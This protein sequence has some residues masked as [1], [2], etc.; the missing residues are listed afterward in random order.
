RRETRGVVKA[1]SRL[2]GGSPGIGDQDPA[3]KVFFPR[4]P[5]FHVALFGEPA[6]TASVVGVQVRHDY[7]ADRTFLHCSG[8]RLLPHA[9]RYIGAYAGVDDRPAIAIFEEPQVDVTE[10]ERE[11]HPQPDDTWRNLHR[12]AGFRPV[13]ELVENLLSYA[14]CY[15]ANPW[16]AQLLVCMIA[17][18]LI[19]SDVADSK[20]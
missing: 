12:L 19:C 13:V 20:L 16:C 4:H 7:P 18:M 9:F 3:Q 8:E 10:R 15:H 6:G 11:R 14:G 5:Q 1:N 2:R 17:R